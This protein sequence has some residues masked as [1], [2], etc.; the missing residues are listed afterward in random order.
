MQCIQ[1][2]LF[3]YQAFEEDIDECIDETDDCD[4]NAI[5]INT[6]GSFTCECESGY[7]GNGRI[8][9]G[10]LSC[11]EISVYPIYIYAL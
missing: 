5:C 10:K 7:T 4:D 1:V 6:D 2:H 11:I 9:E 3:V 8:C